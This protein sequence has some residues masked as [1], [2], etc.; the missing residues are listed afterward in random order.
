MQTRTKILGHSAHQILVVFPF[1]LLV[2]TVLLDLLAL[3]LRDSYWWEL[4]YWTNAGGVVT[5]ILAA[6]FGVR[7]WWSF[8]PAH[9]RKKLAPYMAR[10]TCSSSF[11]LQCVGHGGGHLPEP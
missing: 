11:S 8:Q 2:L 4:A 6:P 1:T 5:A 7:D 9:G 3:V 10:A